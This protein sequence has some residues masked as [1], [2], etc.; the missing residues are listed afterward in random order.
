MMTKIVLA[1]DD[2]DLGQLFKIILK[3]VDPS[4]KLT[5]V[6]DS[7]KLMEALIKKV[8][9]ILFLDLHMPGKNGMICLEEIRQNVLLR[10]LPVV[11]Y[12][13]SSDM[14]DIQRSFQL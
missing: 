1:D 6:N 11:V 13:N 3:Q 2:G 8:P 5:I 9:D 4:K 7:K 12:S 14:N 10:E